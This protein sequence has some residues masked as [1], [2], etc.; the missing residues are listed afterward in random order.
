M[1]HMPG[2]T[3]SVREGWP[4]EPRGQ[5]PLTCRRRLPLL[6]AT[7]SLCD[8]LFILNPSTNDM[9]TVRHTGRCWGVLLTLGIVPETLDC[10]QSRKFLQNPSGRATG[11]PE[12]SGPSVPF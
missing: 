11:P 12:H 6:N 5:H 7:K 3:S 8:V 1:V 10:S 9:A 4:S 2:K